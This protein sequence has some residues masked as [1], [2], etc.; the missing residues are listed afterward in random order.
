MKTNGLKLIFSVFL[1]LILAGCGTSGTDSGTSGTKSIS[2]GKIT[3]KTTTSITV[4]ATQFS[5][6]SA[7]IVTEDTGGSAESEIVSGMVVKVTSEDGVVEEIEYDEELEGPIADV[8]A[9]TAPDLSFTVLGNLVVVDANTVYGKNDAGGTYTVA[10]IVMHDVVEV[11]GFY[12]MDGS[13]LATYIEMNGTHP[14]NSEA[15]IKGTI[16]ALTAT[17]FTIGGATIKY[18]ASTSL[19]G[20]PSGLVEGT[21][22]EVEGTLEA[23]SF[24]IIVASEIENETEDE[25]SEVEVEG[26]VTGYVSDADFMVNGIKVDASA[27]TLNPASLV[28]AD[29]VMVDVEGAMVGGVLVAKQVEQK[30]P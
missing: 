5:T 24:T 4:N 6:T 12:Q 17:Q 19:D 3:T 9:G 10:D 29:G 21:Y 18:D 8:P 28:I 7:D 14:A 11:S 22:V 30:T 15:E 26:M 1:A 25:G 13:L 27:A 23:G 2:K 16:T 20:F